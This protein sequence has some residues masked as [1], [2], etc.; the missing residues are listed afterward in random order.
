MLDRVL[1][2]LR[3]SVRVCI[4]LFQLT[5]LVATVVNLVLQIVAATYPCGPLGH[6]TTA[7]QNSTANATIAANSNTGP[8][9]LIALPFPFLDPLT[10]D[11]R[12]LRDDGVT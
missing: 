3:S 1:T 5:L 4:D 9:Y 8:M 7:H 2:R 12:N 11:L 10:D 6:D